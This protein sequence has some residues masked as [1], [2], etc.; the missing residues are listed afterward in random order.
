MY[1]Y[2]YLYIYI[3][4][5]GSGVLRAATAPHGDQ[6]LKVRFSGSTPAP[7]CAFVFEINVNKQFSCLLGPFQGQN[8]PQFSSSIW[9]P[10]AITTDRDVVKVMRTEEALEAQQPGALVYRGFGTITLQEVGVV[11]L[12]WPSYCLQGKMKGPL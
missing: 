10:T 4:D 11:I 5:T 7:T 12:R 9:V 2:I 1:I 3:W 8:T 6:W